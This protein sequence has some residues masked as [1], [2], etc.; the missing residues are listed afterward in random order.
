METYL[1][2]PL[3]TLPRGALLAASVIAGILLGVVVALQNSLPGNSGGSLANLGAPWVAVAFALGAVA[4]TR[5]DGAGAGALGLVCGLIAFYLYVRVVQDTRT[6]PHK[7]AW[8][9]LGLLGGGGFGALGTY[10]R[11]AT[12]RRRVWPAALM[13]SALTAEG[14]AGMIRA[15]QGTLHTAAIIIFAIELAC[16]LAAPLVLL[17]TRA[18]RTRAYVAVITSAAALLTLVVILTSLIHHHLGG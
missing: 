17:A 1:P 7:W 9:V 13:T 14:A 16:G 11:S 3:R 2:K 15:A 18:E 8:F 10:W 4:A 5:R 12:G 6:P